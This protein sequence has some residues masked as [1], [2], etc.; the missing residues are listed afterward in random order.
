MADT[1]TRVWIE[2]GDSLINA[3]N[4]NFIQ[5]LPPGGPAGCMFTMVNSAQLKAEGA[6]FEQIK[7]ILGFHVDGEKQGEN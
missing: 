1:K 2:I 5:R 6:N 7:G 3:D 4:I